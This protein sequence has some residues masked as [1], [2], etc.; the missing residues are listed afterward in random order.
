MQCLGA[1]D[2]INLSYTCSYFA[3]VTSGE[4]S[5]V[6]RAN[7]LGE[8]LPVGSVRLFMLDMRERVPLS[9]RELPA[10]SRRDIVN[11]TCRP[12]MRWRP[13]AHDVCRC[14]ICDYMRPCSEMYDMRMKI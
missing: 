12:W 5:Q 3:V 4:Y 2:I 6:R 7:A 14:H 1:V 13:V 9:S 11:P 10:L 8:H